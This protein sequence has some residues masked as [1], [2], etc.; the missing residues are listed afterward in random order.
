MTPE[1]YTEQVEA[2]YE[3]E[4]RER[5]KAALVPVTTA[6]REAG[7]TA[8]DPWDGSGDDFRWY[9]TVEGN[10]LHERV[11]VS[12]ELAE[13]LSYGDDT[14]GVNLALDIVA[15]GGRILGGLTPYNYTPNVWAPLDDRA[16]VLSRMEIIEQ[17]DTGATVALVDTFKDEPR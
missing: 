7:Y 8:S 9:V 12:L 14:A 10:G 16:E 11:D 13:S 17:A 15:D 4:L 1:E 3:S 6:F 2:L 5:M